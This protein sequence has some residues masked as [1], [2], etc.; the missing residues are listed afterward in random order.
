MNK[1]SSIKN[2]INKKEAIITVMGLGYV[3]LPIALEFAKKGFIV[4]GLDSSKKRINKLKNGESYI[5][6]VPD[7][8]IARILTKKR[9]YP[10]LDSNILSNS[11]VVII[12]VP[13]PLGKKNKPD[14]SYVIAA[15]RT[16]R[17]NIKKGQIIV[18]EST[19][20]PGTTR[21]VVQPIIEES[22]FEVGKDFFLSFSPE[23][24]D[25]GNPKYNF[26]NIPK[27]VG[28]ITEEGTELAKLLYSKV[29]KEVIA[30]SA[31]EA[32]EV[33]K[34][35]ENTF[36]IVNIGL[37]NEFAVLCDKLGIDVWEVVEAAKTK[38]F[39]FMPFYPGPGVGGHC[40]PADPIYLSWRAKKVGFKTKMIDL[41]AKINREAPGHVVKRIEDTLSANRKNPKSA[42]V[43]LVG[44]AY[45]KDVNDLRESPTLDVISTLKRKGIKWSYYDPY[46]PFL[47]IHG[48]KAKP[49]KL[50]AQAVKKYDLV[51]ILTDHSDVNYKMLAKNSKSILDVRNVFGKKKIKGKNIV[52]L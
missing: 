47:D 2:R 4:N 6:D 15:S 12:C 35:L 43:L 34:L 39:G 46:I 8:E 23:R 3:G 25:P 42:R 40:I 21:E 48:I 1:S 33:T 24:I 45:K 41:A 16:L 51:V 27:L 11:D 14:M 17:D 36:R 18:L 38:P 29:V 32:A 7:K 13:T 5:H 44:V 31:P 50:T 19:T 49:V 9:F 52:K 10:T 20:Y 37:I 22:G 30:L 28:G 26:T